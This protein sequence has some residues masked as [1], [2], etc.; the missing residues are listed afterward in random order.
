[1][2]HTSGWMNSQ[3]P[4]TSAHG[5]CTRRCKQLHSRVP[6]GLIR[7]LIALAILED[8]SVPGGSPLSLQVASAV[9]SRT[10]RRPAADLVGVEKDQPMASQCTSCR[11]LRAD[12]KRWCHL[13]RR[14]SS[15][16]GQQVAADL[17]CRKAPGCRNATKHRTCASKALPTLPISGLLAVLCRTGLVRT[18]LGAERPAADLV[19]D[20]GDQRQQAQLA[21][22]PLLAARQRLQVGAGG[23][24]PW[25][26]LLV[27][28]CTCSTECHLEGL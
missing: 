18:H 25:G 14:W 9:S 19:E 7:L 28:S 3:R 27:S 20:E 21:A 13:A 17:D 2:L 24:R 16:W 12:G 6:L 23:G 26:R 4:A 1:M 8:N 22:V 11:D 5:V 15:E 10:P